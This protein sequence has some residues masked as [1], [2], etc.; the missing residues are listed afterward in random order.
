MTQLCL[1]RTATP[2]TSITTHCYVY[3]TNKPRNGNRKRRS[4]GA[5]Q[6]R[7]KQRTRKKRIASASGQVDGGVMGIK[8]LLLPLL[9]LL[10]QQ[11]Q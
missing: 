9:Q 4:R 11:P 8:E 2:L 1:I 5:R 7:R 10:Q 6:Q 3:R